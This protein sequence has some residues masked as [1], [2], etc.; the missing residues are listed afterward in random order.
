M[1]Q[2]QC[3][4][5]KL[6]NVGVAVNIFCE[7]PLQILRLQVSVLWKWFSILFLNTSALWSRHPGT[8]V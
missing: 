7:M 1:A 2:F 6:S 4:T 8:F 3:L 5:V